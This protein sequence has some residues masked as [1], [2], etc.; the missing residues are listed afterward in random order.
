VEAWDNATVEA[1]DNAT[2]EAWDNATVEA[3]GNAFI[4]SCKNIECKLSDHA[5]FR[6]TGTNEITIINGRYT[7]ILK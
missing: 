5:I 1:W 6:N 4:S 2:V 3:W 7:V